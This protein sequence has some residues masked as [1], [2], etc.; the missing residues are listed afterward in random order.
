MYK[1]RSEAGH[2]LA[3]AVQSQG[4]ELDGVL[5]I[6]RGGTVV[7]A[8]V[9]ETLDKPLD[10]VM[11]RKMGSPNLPEYAVGAVTPD[12]EILVHDRLQGLLDTEHETIQRM[13]GTVQKEINRQLSQFRRSIEPIQLKSRNV[14]LVDDGIATGF[15]VKAAIR[16]LKRIGVG[17]IRIAVPVCSK[18]SYRTLQKEVDD[19]LALQVPEQLFAVS[20]FYQ[21]FTSVEDREVIQLLQ[22]AARRSN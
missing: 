15:T 20:Q 21:D 8:V 5:A 1:N 7:A 6:P 14:L 4:W 11:A 16:Y 12:G 13:A 19:L 17:S 10:V 3:T 18:S 9:A 2:L 22:K